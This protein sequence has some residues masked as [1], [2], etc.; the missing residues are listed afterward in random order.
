MLPC[1]TTIIKP[2]FSPIQE[3]WRCPLVTATK[4][5]SSS[6][7]CELLSGKCQGATAKGQ[8]WGQRWC[9]YLT[10]PKSTSVSSKSRIIISVSLRPKSQDEYSDLFTRR[11]G[12]WVC[13]LQFPE[14]SNFPRTAP[15]NFRP[16]EPRNAI[17]STFRPKPWC[18]SLLGLG[19]AQGGAYPPSQQVKG[20]VQK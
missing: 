9:P 17:L 15:P 3:I 6:S 20:K 11:L 7:V 12:E 8:G 18:P 2:C 5:Q 16:M 13:F 19:V 14:D 1:G 4:N 10:F